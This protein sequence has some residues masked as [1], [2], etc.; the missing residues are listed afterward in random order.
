M[1][2]KKKRSVLVVNFE[3]STMPISTV[4]EGFIKYILNKEYKHLI[5]ECI[6]LA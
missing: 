1:G 5:T 2:K 6:V 3:G 4:N